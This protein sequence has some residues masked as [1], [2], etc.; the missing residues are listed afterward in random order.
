MR[1]NQALIPIAIAA[2]FLHGCGGGEQVRRQ[3]PMPQVPQAVPHRPAPRAVSAATYVATAAS[4]DLFEIR[5]SE[6]ALQRSSSR[7]VREF[8]SMM[9]SA[10]RGTSAQLSYAGRRLNLLPSARLS[11]RHQAM[12]DQ[13]QAA[14]NFDAAYHRQQAAV[15]EEA[16]TLHSG[17]AARGTSPT[18]RPVARAIVPVIQRHLRLLRSL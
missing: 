16:L 4:I 2:L 11:A 17:Y 9:I 5:S 14:P 8:A 10:H 1:R 6:L 13:L 12:F 3:T 15:H 7:R 18:L